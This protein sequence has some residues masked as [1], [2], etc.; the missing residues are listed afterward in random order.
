M[1]SKRNSRRVILGDVAFRYKVSTTPISRGIYRLNFTAQLE[2]N[3]GSKLVVAGL[4]QRDPFVLAPQ[5][6]EDHIYYPT[7]TRHEA[8]WF[9]REAIA[10]GWDPSCEGK[11]FVLEATNEVFRIGGVLYGSPGEQASGG[12]EGSSLK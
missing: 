2:V 7:V 11:D 5:S 9:V 8:N 4:V 3:P 1:F 10:R 6:R 12:A